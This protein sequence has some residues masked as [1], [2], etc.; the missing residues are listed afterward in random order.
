MIRR[1]FV[2]RAATRAVA[3][4]ASQSLPASAHHGWRNAENR[5]HFSA[6]LPRHWPPCAAVAL[7][8][9]RPRHWP[10]CAA[11]APAHPCARDIRT[12]LCSSRSRH[13]ASRDIG[14]S[15]CGKKTPRKISG[16]L[17]LLP[18]CPGL[19]PV[20]PL[21][22]GSPAG[23][24]CSDSPYRRRWPCWT[25]PSAVST[26]CCWTASRRCG[27]TMRT[28]RRSRRRS[29]RTSRCRAGR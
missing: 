4:H 29:N 8:I 3:I 1:S 6:C 17:V 23:R 11:V 9:L 2:R 16:A 10:P 28:C 20:R 22:A 12:S 21:I 25:I 27:T 13:P 19:R 7:R 26:C 18:K 14:T 15:M 24:C 5:E